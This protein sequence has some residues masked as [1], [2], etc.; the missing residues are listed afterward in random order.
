MSL[1]R[2]P[3]SRFNLQ[4]VQSPAG[5]SDCGEERGGHLHLDERGIKNWRMA[6]MFSVVY[7]VRHGE[8][9]LGAKIRGKGFSSSHSS[10]TA[11]QLACIPEGLM[12]QPHDFLG[13]SPYLLRVRALP[14]FDSFRMNQVITDTKTAR[15]GPIFL[16]EWR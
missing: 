3:A 14:I 6:K 2:N 13:S 5:Q 9:F 7:T 15:R 4:G 11:R 16:V 8:G 10:V 12:A 1:A